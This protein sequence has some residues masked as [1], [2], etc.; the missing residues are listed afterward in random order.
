[1]FALLT[2]GLDR[3]Q[4]SKT[5]TNDSNTIHSQLLKIIIMIQY[6][7]VKLN[8]K[9]RVRIQTTCGV[10]LFYAEVTID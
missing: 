2:Q 8:H 1:K 6:D 10:R 9:S 4:C 7:D 5:S 3:S